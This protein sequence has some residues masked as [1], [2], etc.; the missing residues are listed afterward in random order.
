[1]T[2]DT[3]RIVSGFNTVADMVS[4]VLNYFAVLCAMFTVDPMIALFI[5]VIMGSQCVSAGLH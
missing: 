4:Q 5:V 3:A 1:M 2:S